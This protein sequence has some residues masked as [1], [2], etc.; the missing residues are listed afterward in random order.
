M[1][2]QFKNTANPTFTPAQRVLRFSGLAGERLD[3]WVTGWGT[4]G[5]LS[6]AGRTL[7][8]ARPTIQIV[9]A[10]PEQAALLSG[11]NGHPTK[12][13]DGR[14]T[15]FQTCMDR[16]ITD[17]IVPVNEDDPWPAPCVW[18]R[19]RAFCWHL[20]RRHLK[21]IAKIAEQANPVALWSQC[22]R[23]RPSAIFDAAV[24]RHQ[25][26]FR[27]RLAVAAVAEFN[28]AANS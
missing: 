17:H 28:S 15:L 12:F 1:A 23:T 7:K 27:R 3:Y 25:R 6:G 2:Q 21:R 9:A 22:S 20:C 10:E 16:D 8:A 18:R 24:R 26:R 4:G 5:T 14:R 19:K 11:G 13:R